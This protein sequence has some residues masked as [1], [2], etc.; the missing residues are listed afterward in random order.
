MHIR[1]NLPD[2]K[3]QKTWGCRNTTHY[4]DQM[5]HS[6]A[7][8]THNQ[9]PRAKRVFCHQNKGTGFKTAFKKVTPPA[10]L[11]GLSCESFRSCPRAVKPERE[12][13]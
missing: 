10:A 6:E 2:W 13:S 1:K 12:D 11:A 3:D 5:A 8:I 7:C 9:L 4:K